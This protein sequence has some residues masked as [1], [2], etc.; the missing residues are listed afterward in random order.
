MI[1]TSRNDG[2]RSAE[3]STITAA[4]AGERRGAALM[5]VGMAVPDNVVPNER[6]ADRLGV[7]EGWIE[8]RTG[9]AERRIASTETVAGLGAQASERA[10]LAAGCDASDVD[11]VLVAT[12]TPDLITPTV[13][14]D[15]ISM[16]D[17]LAGAGNID[18]NGACTGWVTGLAMAASLVETGRSQRALVVGSDVLSR[19]TDPH[20]RSTAA[21]FADGAGAALVGARDG[22]SR[23][24]PLVTGTDPAGVRLIYGTHDDGVLRMKGGETFGAAVA[25]LSE[26][27][28][29]AAEA[30][31]VALEDIDLFV[32]HQANRRILDAVADSV[33]LDRA[34]VPMT[35]GE[36][37]NTSAATI[38]IALAEAD[39]AGL[40]EDGTVA[41]LAAF[42]SGFTWSA[43]VVEWGP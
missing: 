10:L 31:S 6:V 40:L 1:P 29:R 3:Q 11:L 28:R 5:G 24:G 13:S 26:S 42:A 16:V 38:P 41:L 32:Y 9:V 23:I 33:G 30:A 34:R 20:D 21:L 15:I 14:A 35:I 27:T 22:G 2:R 7:T 39:R 8:K 19:V 17:G 36:Y 43:T 25:R 37:G 4:L 12:M 18:L